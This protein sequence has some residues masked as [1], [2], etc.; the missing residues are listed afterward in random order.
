MQE[1]CADSW[2]LQKV[3]LSIKFALRIIFCPI[4]T[5]LTEPGHEKMCLMAY[6]NNKGADQPT[7]SLYL[8]ERISH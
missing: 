6:A 4:T 1:F 5:S 7:I 2:A 8:R 3:L